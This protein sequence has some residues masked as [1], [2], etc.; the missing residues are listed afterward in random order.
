M[1][2]F[3]GDGASPLVQSTSGGGS[4]TL[5]AGKV[6]TVAVGSGVTPQDKID[7]IDGVWSKV[8]P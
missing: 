5:Y 6:Y 8:L 3:Y 7:I 4:I 2:N 1:T